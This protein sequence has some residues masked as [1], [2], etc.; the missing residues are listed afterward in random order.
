ML[1]RIG[2]G[3]CYFPV[4]RLLSAYYFATALSISF[5]FSCGCVRGLG[6]FP[7]IY[8]ETAGGV[9]RST[10]TRNCCLR[11]LSLSHDW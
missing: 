5:L 9:P 10:E 6:I 11:R 8:R 1:A 3:P 4:M 2:A 7:V